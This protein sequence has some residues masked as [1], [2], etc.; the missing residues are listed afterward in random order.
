MTTSAS[1][2][3]PRKTCL[4]ARPSSVPSAPPPRRALRRAR[5]RSSRAPREQGHGHPPRLEAT[6]RHEQHRVRRR[7]PVA[8]LH[9]SIQER[10]RDA[11]PIGILPGVE[12]AEGRAHGLPVGARQGQA[13]RVTKPGGLFAH[14]L[15]RDRVEVVRGDDRHEQRE[16]GRK[17]TIEHQHVFV[18]DEPLHA[19]RR[20]PFSADEQ[21]ID[22]ARAFS[23]QAKRQGQ[24]GRQKR[25]R[26]RLGGPP[27]RD[28]HLGQPGEVEAAGDQRE[29][30]RG[31]QLG[32]VEQEITPHRRARG[33][34]P[35]SPL[36]PAIG[37]FGL[38]PEWHVGR[39]GHGQRGFARFVPEDHLAHQL[40][41]VALGRPG[42][43]RGQRV[44]ALGGQVVLGRD[45]H[46]GRLEEVTAPIHLANHRLRSAPA[47]QLDEARLGVVVETRRAPLAIPIHRRAFEAVPLELQAKPEAHVGARRGAPFGE[48]HGRQ[49]GL[50]QAP[51]D[52]FTGPAQRLRA[53]PVAVPARVDHPLAHHPC[54][55][56]APPRSREFR[57]F[58]RAWPDTRPRRSARGPS[59][60]PPRRRRRGDPSGVSFEIEE[61]PGGQAVSPQRTTQQRRARLGE[62]RAQ[63]DT[64]SAD[65]RGPRRAAPRRSVT[66]PAAPGVSVP[67]KPSSAADPEIQGGSVT[68]TGPPAS[69]P[70]SCTRASRSASS[71]PSSASS[72]KSPLPG[73]S[74][75]ARSRA[76]ARRGAPSSSRRTRGPSRS[77]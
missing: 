23:F 14:E 4:P 24:G 27:Q 55:P 42:E 19:P 45:P 31:E 68:T 76:R 18:G 7:L 35:L 10:A 30:P 3:A 17:G 34:H 46:L 73:R 36:I 40:G 71:Q 58:R 20:L 50:E 52:L 72:E 47:E 33:G 59:A 62:R 43:P 38:H 57:P 74:G 67:R 56:R 60:S 41:R 51:R 1:D 75:P 64:R 12:A 39:A 5:L 61:H 49:R 6:L 53:G 29:R 16:V 66:K 32:Q 77:A 70:S 9:A 22:R 15:D 28:S 63:D 26:L 8:D 44:Q 69:A 25:R 21:G 65:E 13:A 54:S 37:R 11:P 2:S 48:R